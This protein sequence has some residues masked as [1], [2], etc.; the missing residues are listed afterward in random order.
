MHIT[1]INKLGK[2]LELYT[3]ADYIGKG[4]PIILPKG[5]KLINLIRNFV[6]SE[7]AKLGYKVVRT[8]NVS[9]AEIYK[10]EDRF[11][12]EKREMFII[13]ADDEDE[14]QREDN[15]IV[16][17]PYSAPFH[18]AVY[19]IKQRSYRN[20][21][22]KLSETSTVYRNERDIKG[23]SRTRQIT[24]SDA[25]I[26]V[27]PED[28][29]KAIKESLEL[30]QNFISKLGL[31]V[32]YFVCTWDNSKKENYIGQVDE[33]NNTTKAMKNALDSLDI[34]YEENNKAKMY[35]PSIQIMYEKNE[36]STMQ[37]DFE[38]VHRFDI[39]YVD[40]DNQEKFPIYVHRT[41]VGSYENLLSILIEKYKGEFPL[42]MTP[43]QVVIIPEGDEFEDYSKE[44]LNNLLENSI[45]AEIDNSDNNI[46]N[47]E[48]KAIEQKIPYIISIG[49]EELNSKKLKV[50]TKE[51]VNKIMGI[52]NLIKEVLSC[53]TKY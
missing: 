45:R 14:E 3:Y 15:S 50:R 8:P 30:Q 34:S 9:R 32:K 53:Q 51:T 21:P 19:K 18:C 29:E 28:L 10:I 41:S 49:K 17:R 11:K 35:G 46:Q 20:L 39:T 4:F 26:F 6:E 43:I 12:Q 2:E 7:E 16:L 22:I 42:W 13:E 38:I 47:K 23:I 33:W 31:N 48:Y 1:E 24:L 52:D 40:K 37:V 25:S 5:A 44:I 27:A 36:F